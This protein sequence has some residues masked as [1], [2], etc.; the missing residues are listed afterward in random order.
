VP[1]RPVSGTLILAPDGRLAEN[2]ALGRS[3]N[4]VYFGTRLEWMGMMGIAPG[5]YVVFAIDEDAELDGDYLERYRGRGVPV[6]IMEGETRRQADRMNPERTAFPSAPARPD[7]TGYGVGLRWDRNRKKPRSEVPDRNLKNRSMNSSTCPRAILYHTSTTLRT[8]PNRERENPSKLTL[9][10]EHHRHG[11][12]LFS[13]YCQFA[14]VEVAG[15][16]P[17]KVRGVHLCREYL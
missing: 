7:R 16:N 13:I 4:Y 9:R 12:S 1:D 11:C 6:Q 5:R 17:V 2:R 14:K 3:T 8:P 10:N 15:S